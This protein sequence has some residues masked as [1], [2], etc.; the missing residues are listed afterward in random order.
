MP[1]RARRSVLAVDTRV[2]IVYVT[3][4][5]SKRQSKLTLVVDP[6]I[7][8]RAKSYAYAH[9]VSVSSLVESYLKNLTETGEPDPLSNPRF[10][11][12]TTRSLYGAL[13]DQTNTKAD[14]LK[15][16]YLRKKHLHD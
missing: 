11:P 16:S 7:V 6:A 10:W 1:C 15:L 5:D 3:R 14:D 4:M 8:Q 13:A 12:V 2:N 9:N